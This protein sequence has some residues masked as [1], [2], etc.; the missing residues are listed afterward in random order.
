MRASELREG[1]NPPRGCEGD[2]GGSRN[3]PQN[4][5]EMENSMV[6]HLDSISNNHTGGKNKGPY[7]VEAE[8][9]LNHSI[10]EG[11]ILIPF[12]QPVDSRALFK[13]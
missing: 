2:W 11:C 1:Q 4:A 8:A 7:Q 5:L 10:E 3:R 12:L 9:C 6:A 13:V